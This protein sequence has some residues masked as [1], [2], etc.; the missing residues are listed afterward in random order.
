MT[1][2][3]LQELALQVLSLNER[4]ALQLASLVDKGGARLATAKRR[5]TGG[6]YD[7][8][9]LSGARLFDANGMQVAIVEGVMLDRADID[10]TAF[11]DRHQ[12]TIKGALR[13]RIEA[14]GALL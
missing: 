1:N 3:E 11:G 8:G 13:V 14:K 10:V 7:W 4:E 9:G 6:E 5:L 2:A 12:K